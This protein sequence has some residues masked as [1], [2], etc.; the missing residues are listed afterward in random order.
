MTVHKIVW[1]TFMGD[2]PAGLEISHKDD[3][4]TNNALDNL[5]VITHA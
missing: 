4:K 5:E 3:D 2:V 1:T